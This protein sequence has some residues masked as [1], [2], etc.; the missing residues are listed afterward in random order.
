MTEF[1]TSRDGTR[2]AY[3]RVGEGPAVIL[4]AGAMQ[5][6]AFDPTTVEMAKLLAEKGF[7]VLNYDRR[8]R[9]ESA[10]TTSLTLADSIDDLAAL[11]AATG[12]EVTLF[13]S[14][15]GGAISLAA[16]AAGLPVSS[17]VLW[18]TPLNEEGSSGDAEFLAALRDS[19]RS[20]D[21]EATVEFF[22]KDMPREWVD[23][24][25]NSPA[26]PIMLGIAPSLEP[27]AESLAW[28]QSAPRDTLWRDI[29][30]PTLVLV[31]ENT[32]SIMD[33]AAD[34][35]VAML[36]NAR[37][38]HIRAADHQWDADVMAGEIAA[39]LSSADATARAK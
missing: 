36:A 4:V 31:G 12:S 34:A 23:E 11:I 33:P 18:E 20:G 10:R 7:T 39:F 13:G 6:R 27:D 17:L 37:K 35:I 29:T 32:L 30:Q 14:S 38:R 5:F 2:I 3:D 19:I 24:A 21:A 1:V 25:R 16:A 8:G 26:W 28:T 9:G 22:M 15:S